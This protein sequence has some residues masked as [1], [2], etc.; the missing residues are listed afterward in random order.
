MRVMLN[1]VATLLAER[2]VLA[3]ITVAPIATAATSQDASGGGTAAASSG[4]TQPHRCCVSVGSP[5]SRCQSP[6][7]AQ[8][9]VAPGHLDYYPYTGG[10]MS[11]IHMHWRA[12]VLARRRPDRGLTKSFLG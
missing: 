4:T 2:T 12:W 8:M 6:G 3:A 9:Y 11:S 10:A 5:L 1:Y 7:N